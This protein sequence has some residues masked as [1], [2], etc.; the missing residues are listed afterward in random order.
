MEKVCR[1]CYEDENKGEIIYPCLCSGNIKYVHRLCLDVWIQSKKFSPQKCE[2]CNYKYKIKKTN[3]NSKKMLCKNM[4]SQIYEYIKSYKIF[5][6]IENI[7]LN[8][9]CLSFLTYLV[10]FFDRND[11]IKNFYTN[12]IIFIFP[13][14]CISYY[15]EMYIIN[16]YNRTYNIFLIYEFL[17][18]FVIHMIFTYAIKSISLTSLYLMVKFSIGY[19]MVYVS[20]FLFLVYK[21]YSKCFSN[22]LITKHIKIHK[23]RIY[24]NIIEIIDKFVFNKIDMFF[25]RNMSCSGNILNMNSKMRKMY[26]WNI[27][28]KFLRKNLHGKI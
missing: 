6:L 28:R 7:L 11:I 2:I 18:L 22:Q 25:P 9:L 16:F 15:V 10:T 12:N 27:K 8:Y 13:L 3:I 5:Y 23:L 19:T 24:D 20:V 1:I 21:D 17:F 26:N 4:L 14:V